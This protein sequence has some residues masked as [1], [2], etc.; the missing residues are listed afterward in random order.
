MGQNL[1]DLDA[2]FVLGSSDLDDAVE[3]AGPHKC[4]IEDIEPIGSG[5]DNDARIW[6]ESV[7]L[8][9]KLV[10][11][12]FSL[13]VSLLSATPLPANCVY[14]VDE[15]DC[16]CQLTSLRSQGITALTLT[17]LSDIFTRNVHRCKSPIKVFRSNN[18]TNWDLLFECCRPDPSILCVSGQEG[19]KHVQDAMQACPVQSESN[20]VGCT[21]CIH[22][23][24]KVPDSGSA[25][26]SKHFH[27]FRCIQGQEGNPGLTS[28]SPCQQRF[29]CSW[30]TTKQHTLWDSSTRSLEFTRL[31]EEVYQ[32]CQVYLQGSTSL[33]Q[34]ARM[35]ILY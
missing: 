20:T 1:E 8:D 7:H 23:I 14:L 6:T 30:W 9:Q 19:K 21:G 3:P 32:L 17:G 5:H 18:E 34:T 25:Q 29:P 11:R 27:K 4:R 28:H 31:D 2:S 16:R 12:L 26:A 22:L 35:S 33:S 13:V 24:E 15:D 10:Q